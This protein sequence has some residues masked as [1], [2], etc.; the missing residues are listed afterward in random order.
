M[1]LNVH[2]V[3]D[4]FKYFLKDQ[5]ESVSKGAEECLFRNPDS[6]AIQDKSPYLYI[7]AHTRKTDDQRND[8][9]LWQ[10]RLSIPI[11]ETNSYLFRANSKTDILQIV[12]LIPK[13]EFWSQFQKGNV[14]ES[15]YYAWSIDQFLNN[16]HNLSKPHP[17]DMLEERGRL[18]L[19]SI[20]DEKLQDVR[21]KKNVDMHQE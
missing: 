1:K 4:R 8:R 18:I 21:R 6:L 5:W 9:L 10:P 3:H 2:E 11:P 16:R 14:T 17:E 19:K 12:W 7:F 13:R 15:D 20:V